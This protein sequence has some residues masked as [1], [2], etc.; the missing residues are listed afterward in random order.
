[1]EGEEM[2]GGTTTVV[3]IGRTVRRPVREW[4]EAVQWLLGRLAAAGVRGVP[5]W[6]GVD[7]QGREVLDFLPGVVG[8]Y[9]VP[10]QARRD[11]A[12]TSAARLLRSL[13][14]ATA[15]LPDKTAHPWQ[16]PPVEPVEVICHG[17]F[18]PYNCVF[19]GGET[20]GV[21]DFD[22]AH[23]GPR[24]W[25]LAYAV[26]RF[27]PVSTVE[28]PD[29]PDVPGQARRVRLFLDAYG[30]TRDERRDVVDA[31]GPRLLALVAFMRA[32]AARGDPNFA[33]HIE[34]GHADLYL[35]DV[36]HFEAHR[37]TWDRVVVG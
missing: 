27:A 31:F 2:S 30:R 10:E 1:M 37:A 19:Q 26:Y 29:V 14:D 32:A 18:A 4:S 34:E 35:R 20:T 33:R 15:P 3:R 16:T 22:G 8:T 13:H 21:F 36:E 17:D 24:C 5:R 7:V 25:D 9:P 23:P 6:H 12:L 11:S 28:A